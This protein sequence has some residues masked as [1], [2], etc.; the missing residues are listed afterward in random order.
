MQGL[1]ELLGSIP[2][3]QMLGEKVEAGSTPAPA[4][5]HLLDPDMPAQ[6]LR[7]HMGEMTDQELL[8][9]RAA[10]GWANSVARGIPPY[11]WPPKPVSGTLQDALVELRVD[12]DELLISSPPREL[13]DA[14][15]T[16]CKK[17]GRSWTA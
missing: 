11:K 9:A 3:L 4:P 7:L 8:T 6:E 17:S 5:I 16:P 12:I 15:A 1:L 2:S 10:I 13:G 14:N